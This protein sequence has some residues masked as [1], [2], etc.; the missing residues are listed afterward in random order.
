MTITIETFNYN[1]IIEIYEDI[2]EYLRDKDN[3]IFTYLCFNR[4]INFEEFNEITGNKNVSINHIN[5][6]KQLIISI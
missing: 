6:K 2:I 1:N 4:Q 3:I 5:V